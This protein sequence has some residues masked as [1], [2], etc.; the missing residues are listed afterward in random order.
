MP[1]LPTPVG[2][3]TDFASMMTNQKYVW[4]KRAWKHAREHS[5]IMQF[6]GT[7]SN[8]MCQRITELTKTERGN[9]AVIRLVP[10]LVGDGVTGDHVLLGKEE[11]LEAYDKEIKIDQLRHAVK[12]TGRMNDQKSV[13]QFRTEAKDK[14]GFW[15]AR[16]VDEIAFMLLAGVDF[17]TA[18]NGA[19]R[20]TSGNATGYKLSSLEFAPSGS[21]PSTAPSA[22]RHYRWNNAGVQLEDGNTGLVTAADTLSYNSLLAMRAQMKDDYIRG[23]RSKGGEEF[24]HVFLPPKAYLK[25]KQDSDFQAALRHAM[26]R[27]SSNPLFS[28]NSV[29]VDGMILHEHHKVFNT[30]GL[31]ATNKWGAAGN[32]D[33]ARIAFCGAQALAMCDLDN[34]GHWDEEK[35]DY[36]NSCGI[37]IGK[38]FGMLKPKFIDKKR[39]GYTST[40][41]DF[42]MAVLDV[43]M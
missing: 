18:L 33:G 9:K 36:N 5:F 8:S 41:Q 4:V 1:V 23:V 35:F 43:A 2:S 31:T 28:G 11:K 22:K 26:P 25:L 39:A 14:L 40:E 38:I 32:T 27:S 6:T 10:D 24:Y 42:G 37:S 20:S 15:M 13:F 3:Q 21:P 19:L 16:I 12:N 7:S 29:M 34:M 30:S 17:D